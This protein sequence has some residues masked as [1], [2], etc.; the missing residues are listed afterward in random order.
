M[1]YICVHVSMWDAKISCDRWYNIS[2]VHK[3]RIR[4]TEYACC[5]MNHKSKQNLNLKP[6]AKNE[7]NKTFF[8]CAI[9]INVWNC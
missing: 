4:E 1:L 5:K 6:Q 7:C 3:L 9:L 8:K 2:S